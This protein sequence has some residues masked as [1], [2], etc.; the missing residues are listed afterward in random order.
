MAEQSGPRRMAILVA[1][2]CVYVFWGSTY[3]G[4]H[5]LLEGGF[6][7]FLGASLRLAIAGAVLWAVLRWRRLPTPSVRQ[8][9]DLAIAGGFLF[10]GGNGLVMLAQRSL[11]SGLAATIVAT[12]PL[13]M[14]GVESLLPK[15]ERPGLGAVLGIVVGFGGVA[16]LIGPE[17]GTGDTKAFVLCL[18]APILWSVG[19]LWAKHRVRGVS[20]F[21]V[22]AYE[23]LFAAVWLGLF[24]LLHGELPELAPTVSGWLA[25]AYLIVFGSLVGFSAF[26]YLMA[27]VPV[28]KVT[29]YA[30]V[31]PVVAVFLGWAI[32][33]E[34]LTVRSLGATAVIILGVALVNLASGKGGASRATPTRTEPIPDAGAASLSS[35]SSG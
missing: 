10:V 35:S 22:T 25:L 8:M 32:A 13:W 12:T 3:L 26:V 7:P 9:I 19:G 18:I 1:F 30:Y 6:P 33:G 20:P 34:P 15:G 17:F 24:G 2:A 23:M 28:A 5:Y 16:V 27:S 21:T 4:I 29:T 14:T 11:P 31:N